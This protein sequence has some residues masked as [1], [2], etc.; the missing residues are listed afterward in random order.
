MPKK[1]LVKFYLKVWL[2]IGICS[3]DFLIDLWPSPHLQ[4]HDITVTLWYGWALVQRQLL[5]V[6]DYV[7]ALHN[8]RPLQVVKLSFFEFL[9]L[10]VI[11]PGMSM[12]KRCIFLWVWTSSPWGFHTV[13]V[14]YSLSPSLSGIDPPMRNVSADLAT[15]F[16]AWQVSPSGIGSAYSRS[17]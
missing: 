14:L 15:S 11:L 4:S 7:E 12:S 3:A 2:L 1:S 13:S 16:N 9:P 6:H 17:W 10:K 5:L 8:L